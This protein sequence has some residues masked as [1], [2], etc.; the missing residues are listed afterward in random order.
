MNPHFILILIPF[1]EAGEK[2]PPSPSTPTL[3]DGEEGERLYEALKIACSMKKQ[4]P[5]IENKA[6]AKT[7]VTAAAASEMA[8]PSSSNQA[9]TESSLTTYSTFCFIIIN[10]LCSNFIKLES[11]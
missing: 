10:S 1:D 2:R 7:V 8:K 5:P 6:V 11:N 3:P 4:Q 9:S